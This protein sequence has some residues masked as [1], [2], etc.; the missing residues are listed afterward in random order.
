[1]IW[2]ELC[3]HLCSC[4]S[5][6]CPANVQAPWKQQWQ[7]L[8]PRVPGSSAPMTMEQGMPTQAL[9]MERAASKLLLQGQHEQGRSSNPPLC[10]SCCERSGGTD[11]QRKHLV[12]VCRLTIVNPRSTIQTAPVQQPWQEQQQ[13]QCL[14]QHVWQ[15]Q[16]VFSLLHVCMSETCISRQGLEC[17]TR[18]QC[19]LNTQD[20]L[21]TVLHSPSSI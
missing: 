12:P 6:S 20:A 19:L 5:D 9:P 14:R 8:A 18:L 13:P 7:K 17:L 15:R 10:T 2:L 16:Q 4:L 1:M 3:P 11:R 21:R